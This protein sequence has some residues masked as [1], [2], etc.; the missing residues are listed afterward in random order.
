[1]KAIYVHVELLKHPLIF[2]AILYNY[3]DLK[4]RY[5]SG[6]GLPLI[7]NIEFNWKLDENVTVNNA[8]FRRIQSYILSY[9]IKRK[10]TQ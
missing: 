6:L 9:D 5:F 1:M 3:S 8:I 4:L 2:F 10:W 7:V